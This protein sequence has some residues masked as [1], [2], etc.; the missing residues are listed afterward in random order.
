MFEPATLFIFFDPAGNADVLHRRHKH[1]ITAGERH[2][3][4]HARSLGADRTLGDLHHQLLAFF[5]KILNG[6]G[7]MPVGLRHLRRLVVQLQKRLAHFRR[8][9]Q[10]GDMHERGLVLA[11]VDEGGL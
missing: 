9:D 10:L 2:I 4:G 11:D 7:T 5:Q 8:A 3:R 1:K 6:L